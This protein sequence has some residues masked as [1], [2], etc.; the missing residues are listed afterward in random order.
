MRDDMNNMIIYVYLLYNSIFK[1]KKF[2]F[3]DNIS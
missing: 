3:C 1:L 2:D